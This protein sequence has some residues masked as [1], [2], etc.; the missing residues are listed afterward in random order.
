M[1]LTE[2]PSG[3]TNDR[4][5]QFSPVTAD[6]GEFLESA[7]KA[8]RKEKLDIGRILIPGSS[9]ALIRKQLDRL[10]FNRAS[11]FPE[12]EHQVGYVADAFRNG[13]RGSEAGWERF[14][15]A[16]LT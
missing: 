9:K 14:F 8:F 10:G 2:D 1:N 4:H 6:K 5:I 3:G 12:L 11:L 7:Q 16:D 13:Y 15:Q